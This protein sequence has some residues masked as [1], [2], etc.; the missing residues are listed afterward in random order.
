MEQKTVHL[1]GYFDSNFGDDWMMT[2]VVRSLPEITFAV[3]RTC[4]GPVLREPNVKCLP[5]KE[6]RKLP[7]LIVTGSGFMINGNA[8]LK[9]ELKMLLRGQ[10][11]GDY[12]LGC[13]IEPLDSK[14]KTFLISR[15]MNRYK[16]ITCRD[17]ESYRWIRSH[18]KRP[19]V[20][21]LPDLLFSFPNAW[22][23]MRQN[24]QLLGISIMHRSEDKEDCLYYAQMAEVA[25]SWVE[26]TGRGVLLMAFDS[27]EEDDVFA[28]RTVKSLCKHSENVQIVTHKN[29]D[30]IPKAFARCEKIVGARFHSMVLAIKMGIPFFPLI[31]RQKMRNVLL[32]L[33]YP[34][35]GCNIDK[36]DMR[37][38]QSFLYGMP[39]MYQLTEMV[40]ADAT[41]HTHLFRKVL[42]G[43]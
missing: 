41:K 11:L 19:K 15:K 4:N 29:G 31:F 43:D 5:T 14:L 20:V 36:I 32:D 18:V 42:N 23:P 35:K 6:L 28:C 34:V 38:I 13:N 9:A 12:C 21:Y 22:L 25:D 26:Q 1:I 10:W 2:L 30:E 39:V 17:K 37:E 8:A 7:A 40:A 33:R 24:D 3:D 27:G 16:L